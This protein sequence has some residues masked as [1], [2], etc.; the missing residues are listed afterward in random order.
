M[1]LQQLRYLAEVVRHDFNISHT[2]QAL[3][4]SQPGISKQIKQL[5]D[6]LGTDLFLR[7]GRNLEGL[8]AAGEAVLPHARTVM[9]ELSAI[10]RIA[11]EHKD[12]R[13][14][15]LA[16]ATT[17][18]QS[19]YVLPAVIE[20]FIGRYPDVSLHMHQGTPM[21]ISQLAANG[22][23][24]FA[25]ATEALEHFEDLVM[26]PCYSWNRAIL[27][28]ADHSLAQETRL[29]IEKLARY[30][31]VTYTFGFT[32]R[33]RL[34]E[35][36]QQHALQPQV[37]FTAADADVIKTYVRLGLGV[38]IVAS[39]AWDPVQDTDLIAIDASHLFG[40]S[41][42][43]IGL[44]RSVQLRGYMYEFL[45]MFAPQLE[46]DLVNRMLS[47]KS[48]TEREALLAGVKVPEHTPAGQAPP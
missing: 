22:T 35:A 12:P 23:A 40:P 17:H 43:S 6:A 42:T 15:T 29:T 8:T 7:R 3:F 10:K 38:G 18:T 28:P 5:E 34:D 30:P 37:V 36:F 46:T 32:G 44:R 4:T 20:R 14:G 16:I 31:L 26:M 13:R 41:V 47:S 45:K 39:M 9:E 21:Q 25:I 27:V 1:K 19:R 24:D 2:A 48:A 33:S 11:E